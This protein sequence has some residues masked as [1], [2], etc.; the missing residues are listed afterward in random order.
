[1]SEDLDEEKWPKPTTLQR[2]LWRGARPVRGNEEGQSEED[3]DRPGRTGSAKKG[4]RM[5]MLLL[6]P[7]LEPA[8]PCA[9]PA[10]LN[11]WTPILSA[12]PKVWGPP[13]GS[14]HSAQWL[15]Q[16]MI[17]VELSQTSMS[18]FFQALKSICIPNISP[19]MGLKAQ[20]LSC[21]QTKGRKRNSH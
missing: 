5:E 11:S 16:K 19:M 1:M 18:S 10:V 14:L 13:R 15:C 7:S 20:R 12:F 6:Q 4:V 8:L 9:E 2:L 17:L 3:K 21:G